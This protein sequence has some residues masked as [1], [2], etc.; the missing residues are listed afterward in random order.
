MCPS[1]ISKR[2][3]GAAMV[4]RPKLINGSCADHYSDTTIA[5]LAYGFARE[6]AAYFVERQRLA[7]EILRGFRAM[8]YRG[9]ERARV[10]TF[11]RGELVLVL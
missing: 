6:N 11:W 9:I 4:S 3:W 1:W 5:A 7:R 10:K 2:R 8:R